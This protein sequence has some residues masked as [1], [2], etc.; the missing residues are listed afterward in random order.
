MTFKLN[1]F[2]FM[3]C[4]KRKY[5]DETLQGVI[6]IIIL[7]LFRTYKDVCKFVIEI[8]DPEGY[9]RELTWSE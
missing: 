5:G 2:I 1:I 6:I 7:V 3:S 4:L 8:D 9:K